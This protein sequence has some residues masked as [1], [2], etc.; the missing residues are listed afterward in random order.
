MNN[1]LIGTQIGNINNYFFDQNSEEILKI[2]KD[3]QYKVAEL[4]I[5]EKHK[6]EIE[7]HLGKEKDNF[8]SKNPDVESIREDFRKVNEILK[9]AKTNS[10]TL[11][12]IGNLVGKIALLGGTI[13]EKLGWMF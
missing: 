5:D 7:N 11:K 10:E 8:E 9:E 13:P 4:N 6:S 12:E 3:I 1:P 2:I